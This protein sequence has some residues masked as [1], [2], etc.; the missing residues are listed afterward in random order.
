MLRKIAL[1]TCFHSIFF[2]ATYLVGRSLLLVAGRRLRR[3]GR[4]REA[5]R[6]RLVER[7]R[8]GA[9]AAAAVVVASPS[10][11][12]VAVVAVVAVMTVVAAADGVSVLGFISQTSVF[13][14]AADAA[15]S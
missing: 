12:A 11:V 4:G 7:R 9:A 15:D 5:E 14:N 6:P 8:G 3:H 13:D 1:P 2:L 10:P